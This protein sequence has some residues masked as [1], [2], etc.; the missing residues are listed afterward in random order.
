MSN[1]ISQEIMFSTDLFR[2]PFIVNF[3]GISCLTFLCVVN[4]VLLHIMCALLFN[5]N[6]GEVVNEVPL[7]TAVQDNSSHTSVDDL[8]GFFQKI[9][10]GGDK[11]NFSKIEGG[12]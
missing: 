3:C 7:T 12:P 1:L 8:Q 5:Q 11:S 10:S 2:Q 6:E 9:N 4:I